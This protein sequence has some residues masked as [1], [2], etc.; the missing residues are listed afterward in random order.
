MSTMS[1]T[2]KEGCV[3][4]RTTLDRSIG[5]GETKRGETSYSLRALLSLPSPPRTRER[6]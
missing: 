4:A 3:V 1:S 2:D 6:T 5:W